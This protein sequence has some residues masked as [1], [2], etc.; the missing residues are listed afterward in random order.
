MVRVQI[1]FS[2]RSL[3]CACAFVCVWM[4]VHTRCI[5][6]A[7][8]IFVVELNCS[9]WVVGSFMVF[10]FLWL[11][12]HPFF[13]PFAWIHGCWCRSRWNRLLFEFAYHFIYS[14]FSPA[15]ERVSEWMNGMN[16]WMNW[17]NWMS[18]CV[19]MFFLHSNMNIIHVHCPFS[20]LSCCWLF[21]LVNMS[22]SFA[23]LIICHSFEWLSITVTHVHVWFKLYV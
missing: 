6:G 14:L 1:M 11:L 4:F 5:C 7:I 3:V 21:C 23:S 9:H 2:M 18:G 17:M 15:S 22:N 16:E 10:L 20:M 19:R 8:S 13:R 12:S